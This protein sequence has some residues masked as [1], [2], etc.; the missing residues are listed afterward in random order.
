[1][2]KEE[3]TT[4][5]KTRTGKV[6]KIRIVKEFLDSKEKLTPKQQAEKYKMT[7]QKFRGWVRAYKQGKLD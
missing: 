3:K 1:M 5:T 7:P 4:K 6:E 2:K